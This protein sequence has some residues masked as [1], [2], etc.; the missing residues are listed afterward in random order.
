MRFASKFALVLALVMGMFL[1]SC[2]QNQP[3]LPEQSDFAKEGD[4]QL[5]VINGD[6]DIAQ[7][8]AEIDAFFETYLQP[9][10]LQTAT[11][12]VE[13]DVNI[14]SPPDGFST[15]D[16]CVTVVGTAS[17]IGGAAIDLY[18]ILDT[19]GSLFTTDPADFREQAAVALINGLNPAADI[20]I[21]TI[22]FDSNAFIASPLTAI[23]DDNGAAAI[24]A[25]GAMDQSG[26]TAIHLGINVAVNDFNANGRPGASKVAILF[27]D[28][29]SSAPLATSAANNAAA[30]GVVVNTVF[31]GSSGAG[32]TLMNTIA[33]ITGG[34]FLQTNNPADLPALFG[35]GPVTGISQVTVN[36]VVAN[37]AAGVFDAEICLDCGSNL[38]IAVATANDSAGTTGADSITVVRDCINGFF[39]GGGKLAGAGPGRRD[40]CTFGF[41]AGNVGFGKD[42]LG[43]LQFNDHKNNTR[44]HGYNVKTFSIS[45]DEKTAEWTG[46]CKVNNLDG[47]T[48]WA[49]ATDNGEPGVN[50]EF[51]IKVWDPTGVMILNKGG[52][53][54]H[55][56]I[57]SHIEEQLTFAP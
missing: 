32:S 41:N 36:G 57:Q 49:T 39:T 26:G 30:N 27:S 44:V 52:V 5:A 34:F 54:L 14:T 43:N 53:L 33:G 7:M 38:I 8:E 10:Y 3:T 9:L 55:G 29:I 20:R 37:L 45:A 6:G 25:I 46:D 24:A 48:F 19:S 51:G 50:D 21:G 56:N 42:L 13:V 15:E 47:Y 40:F 11:S 35:S 17:A 16:S 31:L 1:V 22:D 12:D 28:G 18:L 23:A 2:T 4:A